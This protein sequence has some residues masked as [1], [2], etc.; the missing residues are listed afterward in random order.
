MSNDDSHLND[1]TTEPPPRDQSSVGSAV[2]RAA[3]MLHP[4]NQKLSNG[5]RAELRRANPKSPVT[6]TLWKVLIELEQHESPPYVSPRTWERR[7]AALLVGM[8]YCAGLHEYN[9]SFGKALASAGWSEGRFVRL[10]EADEEALPFLVRRMS[11]YL[12]SKAQPANWDDV[13]KLIFTVSS[14]YGEDVRLDISRDYYR[15]LYAK[16]Q[17]ES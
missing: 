2:G 11:Q 5:E 7:W 16:A 8:S 6:P 15:A 17:S 10:M 13:R 9:V 12:A 3:G 1:S 4:D 14:P